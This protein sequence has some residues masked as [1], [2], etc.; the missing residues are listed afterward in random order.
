MDK[1]SLCFYCIRKA[2]CTSFKELSKAAFEHKVEVHL[3]GCPTFEPLE[4]KREARPDTA[5][6]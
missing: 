1:L 2:D 4:V 3:S 6:H 5:R